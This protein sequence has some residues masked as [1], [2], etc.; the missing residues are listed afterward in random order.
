MGATSLTLSSYMAKYVCTLE[1]NLL[2]PTHTLL[3]WRVAH[4]PSAAQGNFP[5][6]LGLMGYHHAEVGF[7]GLPC[8]LV[9]NLLFWWCDWQWRSYLGAFGLCPNICILGQLISYLHTIYI[10]IYNL[11]LS[12]KYVINSRRCFFGNLHTITVNFHLPQ[13]E[14]IH[15]L[16]IVIEQQR[17]VEDY[18]HWPNINLQKQQHLQK[19]IEQMFGI[20]F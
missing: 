2:S 10:Y 11:L 13:T 15:H 20:C 6:S 3:L 19:G 7:S 17:L 12:G 14:T 5:L 1:F 4:Y 16:H 8:H 9:L 18:L